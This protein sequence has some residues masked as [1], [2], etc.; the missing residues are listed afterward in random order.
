M[1]WMLPIAALTLAVLILLL[2]PLLKKQ[3]G[4]DQRLGYDVAVYRDQM[5]EVD[6]DLER[7]ILSPEQAETTKAE[8]QRRMLTAAEADQDQTA[9]DPRSLETGRRLRLVFALLILLLLPGGA[10]YLYG[11]FGAPGLPSQPFAERQ[12]SPQFRMEAMIEKLKAQLEATPDAKGY[13]MLASSLR[14]M[15]RLS[16]AIEAYRKA[17][18]L[19]ATDAGTY[20]SLG[21]ALAMSAQGGVGPD[22]RA[23]F[24]QALSQDPK[25]PRARFYMGLSEVQIGKAAEGV[26]IWRDLLN[27]SPADAPWRPMVE[28]NIA[29]VAAEAKLDPN[30]IAPKAPSIDGAPVAAN[31]APAMPQAGGNAAQDQMILKMVE[32]L[33]AKMEKNPGD[34]EGWVKLSRSYRVLNQFD[35]AKA[36]AQKAI[37]L[38]PKDTDPLLTLADAQLGAATGDKLPADFLETMAKVLALDPNQ[39]DALYYVGAGELEAGHADKTRVLWTKLIGLLPKDSADRPQLQKQLDELP[40]N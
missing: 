1:I 4:A 9:V 18:A 35:K 24:K 27:D 15:G 20:S 23:A 6:R 32:G 11:L 7:G 39:N 16:D 3:S 8:V 21:E 38:K 22:A 19:G 5:A 13:V 36:A 34:A 10:L 17:I 2:W 30:S 12:N 33:A 28:Q 14:Q 31:P 26:A 40:K 37:V 25:D 29:K